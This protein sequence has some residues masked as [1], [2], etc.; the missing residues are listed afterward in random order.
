[1]R[2]EA[3]SVQHRKAV[4]YIIED[5]DHGYDFTHPMKGEGKLLDT[6]CP[7]CSKPFQYLFIPGYMCPFI[8]KE[9]NKATGRIFM[10]YRP[11][12]VV[13]SNSCPH[14]KKS[15]VKF[16]RIETDG[17]QILKASGIEEVDE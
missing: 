10:G 15:V 16:L 3:N 1:M 8:A 4:E 6:I 13:A 17:A 5:K 11:P 7:K 14:C 9:P 12:R 2:T